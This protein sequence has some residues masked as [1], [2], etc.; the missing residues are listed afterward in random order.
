MRGATRPALAR[1]V[2]RKSYD[3]HTTSEIYPAC[4]QIVF[5]RL[6]PLALA[7]HSEEEHP[8]TLPKPNAGLGQEALGGA[9]S[10]RATCDYLNHCSVFT[11]V[12]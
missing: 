2:S 8:H 12:A 11:K 4:L 7:R 6:H 5:N 3:N 9:D 10:L 1:K